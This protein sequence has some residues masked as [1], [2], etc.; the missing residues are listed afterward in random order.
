VVRR[1]LPELPAG[2]RRYVRIDNSTPAHRDLHAYTEH[3]IAI[4]D[5]GSPDTC[6]RRLADSAAATGVRHQLLMVEAA[7]DP[8]LVASNINRLAETLLS[9]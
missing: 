8:T 3:L 1:A 2:T 7:G 9:T 4:G 5:V 6:R